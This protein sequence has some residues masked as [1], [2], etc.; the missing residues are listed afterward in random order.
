MT[1]TLHAV[2]DGIFFL[3]VNRFCLSV[4]RVEIRRVVG[5]VGQRIIDLVIAG[6][7]IVGNIFD[8][9]L[10]MLAEGH[11]PKAVQ[12]A[13]G[14]DE[15]RQRAERGES[16]GRAVDIFCETIAEE[17]SHRRFHRREV[18]IIPINADDNVKTADACHPYTLYRA[19]AVDVGEREG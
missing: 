2:K 16:A 19:H 14:R 12:S 10:T 17:R 13:V 4:L 15:Y 11:L 6:L 5:Y 9:D 3:E 7:V 1:A 8:R 18:L